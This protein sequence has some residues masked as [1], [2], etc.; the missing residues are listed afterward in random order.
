MIL[1][2]IYISCVLFHIIFWYWFYA[3]LSKNWQKGD[4]N[5]DETVYKNS[6]PV[7]VII[8]AK[9]EVHNLQKHLS[10]ILN[11]K[12]PDF[13]VLVVDDHS[14]DETLNVLK[15]FQKKHPHL[16]VIES[17]NFKDVPGKK[18]AL[19]KAIEMAKH[20]ILLF[21]DAD[22]YPQQLLLDTRNKYLFYQRDRYCFRLRS[23]H[24]N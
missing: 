15:T 18:L 21:T 23:L 19:T 14:K 6:P 16:K 9:N 20:D 1:L 10:Q 8:C 3:H 2:I 24:K 7:S 4:V 12:Y 17:S 5:K 22:C 13:E 11:Q